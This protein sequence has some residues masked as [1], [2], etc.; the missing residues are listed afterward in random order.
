MQ[1]QGIQSHFIFQHIDPPV[2]PLFLLLLFFFSDGYDLQYLDSLNE[3]NI[4]VKNKHVHVL[5]MLHVLT[6]CNRGSYLCD[7]R[8]YAFNKLC[9]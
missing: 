5:F 2:A 1:G 3:A 9:L 8:K 4:F 7:A 6:V